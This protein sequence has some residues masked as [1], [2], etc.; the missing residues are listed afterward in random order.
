MES[1]YEALTS[2]S[3][4]DTH[5]FCI[6]D[7]EVQANKRAHRLGQTKAVQVE[8]LLIKNS[9]E[10]TKYQRRQELPLAGKKPP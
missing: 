4:L 2:D 1:R 9:F 3:I 10:D 6:L 7:L 5:T 8:I